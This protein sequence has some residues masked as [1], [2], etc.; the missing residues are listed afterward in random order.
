M[1]NETTFTY[2]KKTVFYANQTHLQSIEI[3]TKQRF[4][5][6]FL[7]EFV[8]AFG[9]LSSIARTTNKLNVYLLVLFFRNLTYRIGRIDRFYCCWKFDDVASALQRCGTRRIE[10]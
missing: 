10:Q 8:F 1:N 6:G 3:R 7:C 5:Y 9:D 2:T 4:F